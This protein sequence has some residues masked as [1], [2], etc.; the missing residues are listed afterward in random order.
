MSTKVFTIGI[1]IFLAVAFSMF[2]FIDSFNGNLNEAT[3]LIVS[4]ESFPTYLETH[5]AIESMPRSSS[6][7][8][9]IGNT[10]YEIEGKNVNKIS[11]HSEEDLKIIL[12]ENYETVIGEIGLCEAIRKANSENQLKVELYTNK[13]IL[14]MKYRKLL[15][16]SECLQ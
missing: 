14:L 5:P 15:K 4:E 3:G 7:G 8:L 16:Y 11:E 10:N 1:A 9:T 6:V 13:A 12:P 2:L